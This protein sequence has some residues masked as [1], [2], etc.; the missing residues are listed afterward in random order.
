[1]QQAREQQ[2]LPPFVEA[3]LEFEKAATEGNAI[4]GLQS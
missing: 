2:V 3:S 1:M 4:A